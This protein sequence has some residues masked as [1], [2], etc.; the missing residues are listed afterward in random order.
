MNLY[1]ITPQTNILNIMRCGLIPN[2]SKG[3]SRSISPDDVG[4]VWLTDSPDYIFKTQLCDS[5]INHHQPVLLEIDHTNLNLYPRTSHHLSTGPIV[6]PHEFWVEC[7]VECSRI[8]IIST[9][10]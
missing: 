7:T 3:L 8:S 9:H 1:H 6:I 2:Y 5:W 10:R 4:K